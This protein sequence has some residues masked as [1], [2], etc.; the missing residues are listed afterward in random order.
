MSE[1]PLVIARRLAIRL[2]HEAQLSPANPVRG[3]LG[4]LAGE[5]TSVYPWTG[6]ATRGELEAQIK[7]RGEQP[8]AV[9]RSNPQA[10]ALPEDADR[11][12]AGGA[13]VLII[14]LD[15]KGV[16]EMRC[17]DWRSGTAQERILKIK[18]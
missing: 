12:L 13:H 3:L 7:A 9:Y 17:W 14:S 1:A 16:L 15:T 10:P 5:P 6:A 4:A 18:D 11:A 8:W 2:L